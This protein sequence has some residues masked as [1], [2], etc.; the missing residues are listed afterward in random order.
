LAAL[1]DQGFQGGDFLPQT[2][3]SYGQ[4]EQI[5]DMQK[6]NEPISYK[7]AE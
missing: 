2:V 3:L 6:P 4:A 1:F 5:T 7:Y